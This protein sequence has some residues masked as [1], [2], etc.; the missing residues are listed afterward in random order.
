M[1]RQGSESTAEEQKLESCFKDGSCCA[2]Q[3]Q[4]ETAPAEE[5][6][7]EALGMLQNSVGTA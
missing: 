1:E 7:E 4:A 5:L 3:R 6:P 2:G